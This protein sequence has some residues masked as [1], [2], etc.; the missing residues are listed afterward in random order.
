MRRVALFDLDSRI[1]NFAP[2]ESSSYFKKR[3]FAVMLE[4]RPRYLKADS[5]L[6]S[7]VFAREPIVQTSLHSAVFPGRVAAHLRQIT[8]R[9]PISRQPIFHY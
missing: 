6:A 7:A 5:Y 1:P 9:D 3:G 4:R 8:H 2:L